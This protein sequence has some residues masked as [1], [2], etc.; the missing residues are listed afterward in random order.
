MQEIVDSI[1]RIAR[2]EADRLWSCALGVVSSVH[3]GD[4]DPEL[5]C[6]VALRETGLVLPRVPIAVG[7]LG[8][9]APPVE[10]DLVL[11]V[12]A[13]GDPHAPVVVGRL[14]DERVAPPKNSPGQVVA[15]LPRAEADDTKRLE[16]ALSTPG[17][18]TRTAALT[19]A[20]DVAVTITVTDQLVTLA[21]GDTTVRLS[22]SSSSDGKVEVV[23]GDSTIVV[24]QSG[25]VTVRAAGK[26][27]LSGDNV[28]ISATSEVTVAGQTIKLN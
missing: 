18:G 10:G 14:Y 26:L 12:F 19:L 5:S 7:V 11:V 3:T 27:T 24:E 15:W 9:A 1:R 28:E 13:G 21:V 16:I 25:D 2:A 6:T 8:L 4:D 23:V 20:G 22:Q 17:D